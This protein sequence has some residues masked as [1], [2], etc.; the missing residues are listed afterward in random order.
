MSSTNVVKTVIPY[1][2]PAALTAYYM[3][4]FSLIPGVGALLGPL[5]VLLGG[6]GFYKATKDPESKGHIHGIIGV[7][8]GGFVTVCH[9]LIVLLVLL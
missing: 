1:S 3:A 7:L 9:I 4:I 6:F 8:L 5:A 2:N